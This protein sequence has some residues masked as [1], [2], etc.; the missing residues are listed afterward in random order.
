MQVSIA[1]SIWL[2]LA[3]SMSVP[4]ASF[5]QEEGPS[6]V[7]LEDDEERGLNF[8]SQAR[9]EDAYPLIWSA[10]RRG[11]KKAQ[12][13]LGLMYVKGEFVEQDLVKGAAWLGVS[14]ETRVAEWVDTFHSIT[15]ALDETQRTA[16]RDKLGKY[17]EYYGMEAQGISCRPAPL[18]RAGLVCTKASGE[19]PL[20]DYQ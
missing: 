15:S 11:L 17:I 13:T 19:Y 16:A 3:L 2:A 10:A 7:A 18:G 1:M 12:Y 8:Y 6:V 5:A 4:P 14:T 9:F 20:H